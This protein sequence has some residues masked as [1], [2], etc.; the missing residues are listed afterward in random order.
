MPEFIFKERVSGVGERLY[1][2][3]L[4]RQAP[5]GRTYRPTRMRLPNWVDRD[6][7]TEGVDDLASASFDVSIER[8]SEARPLD[9]L[10]DSPI[11]PDVSKAFS[12]EQ[13]I[14][15]V[16][17]EAPIDDTEIIDEWVHNSAANSAI[18]SGWT[19]EYNRNS[20]AST[21]SG[22]AQTSG[23]AVRDF[24]FDGSET[25]SQVVSNGNAS[26]D[27]PAGEFDVP[28]GGGKVKFA[29]DSIGASAVNST[30]GYQFDGSVAQYGDLAE[31]PIEEPI[32]FPSLY[33]GDRYTGGVGF[34]M[35]NVLN[36][37]PSEE[38]ENQ[39]VS[40]NMSSNAEQDVRFA[41]RNPNDYS[42]TVTENTITVPEGTSEVEF[43]VSAQPAVPPVAVEMQDQGGSV[44]S[45]ESYSMEAQ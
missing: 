32:R 39:T 42:E 24:S 44:Q 18:L 10:L 2:N 8:I 34:E 13:I 17:E 43:Q 12:T 7:M 26:V 38:S 3:P 4:T 41:F 20:L 22:D 5:D 19:R 27:G 29:E 15:E 33:S 11:F 30:G 45:V 1:N 25:G 9:I 40:F 36:Q 16:T 31:I 14:E 28:N 23:V 37:A 6:I 35:P 21:D